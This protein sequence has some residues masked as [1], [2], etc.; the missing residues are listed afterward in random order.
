[1]APKAKLQALPEIEPAIAIAEPMENVQ[2]V[3][4]AI[5]LQNPAAPA[6]TIIAPPAV[7]EGPNL[8]GD[9]APPALPPALQG[10]AAATAGRPAWTPGALN[11][12][13]PAVP[14]N[15]RPTVDANVAQASA[16]IQAGGVQLVNPAALDV[17]QTS[18]GVE[19][20]IYVEASDLPAK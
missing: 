9:D 4:P 14:T 5:G 13:P 2:A 3:T 20:A 12:L 1:M 18:G 17:D 7:L 15:L 11:A 8:K 6:P 19:Q 16:E 10:V